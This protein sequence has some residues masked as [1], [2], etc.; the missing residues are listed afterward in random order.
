MLNR[1][2]VTYLMSARTREG[3]LS[4]LLVCEN[5]LLGELGLRH[6]VL[7]ALNRWINDGSV[8]FCTAEGE[9]DS[10]AC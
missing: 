1:L 8:E 4:G 5:H 7:V 6:N 2:R 9:E 3:T 10:V